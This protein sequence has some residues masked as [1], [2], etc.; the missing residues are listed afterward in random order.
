[1]VPPLRDRRQ[2]ISPLAKRFCRTAAEENQ[3]AIE[4]SDEA[5]AILEKQSWPGNVREL[6]NFVE[7]LVVFS[8]GDTVTAADVEREL[9]RTPQPNSGRASAGSLADARND[10]ERQRI[11]DALG[12]AKGNRSLAARLL[13]ISRRTLYN[14]MGELGIPTGQK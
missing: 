8:D 2:D 4:M 3:K 1:V 12:R 9:E 6:Q 14:K 5:I 10:A 11:L 7:R 13:D